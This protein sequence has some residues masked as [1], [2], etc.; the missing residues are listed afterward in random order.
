MQ[1]LMHACFLSQVSEKSKTSNKVK[2][3]Y[4][5]TQNILMQATKLYSNMILQLQPNEELMHESGV[6][7]FYTEMNAPGERIKH[8]GK[9]YRVFIQC[10]T[11]ELAQ[12]SFEAGSVILYK[13]YYIVYWYKL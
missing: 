11:Q 3:Y 9:N 4:M 2:V 8:P 12:R 5:Y 1:V 13:V 6:H 7:F 10:A